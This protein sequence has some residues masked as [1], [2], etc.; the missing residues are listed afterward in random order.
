MYSF[1]FHVDQEE[2]IHRTLDKA[3]QAAFLMKQ[4][5]DRMA[6]AL[7]ADLAKAQLQRKLQGLHPLGSRAGAAIH[8]LDNNDIKKH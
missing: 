4:T 3:L 7:S 6:N 2:S 1:V 5:T 8:F